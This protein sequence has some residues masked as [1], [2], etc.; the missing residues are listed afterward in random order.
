MTYV[1]NVETN[2]TSTLAGP[3]TKDAGAQYA[4]SIT[5]LVQLASDGSVS[6]IPYTQGDSSANSAAKWASVANLASVAP[7]SSSAASGKA[8]ATGSNAATGSGAA[9]TATGSGSASGAQ[10]TGSGAL[11]SAPVSIGALAAGSF[12][13]LLAA[14]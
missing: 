14:L 9:T 4:A 1:I 5:A 8:T 13:A 10:Q 6:Y 12:L 2:T 3:T 7:A 11:A